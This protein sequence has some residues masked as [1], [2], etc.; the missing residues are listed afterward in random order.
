MDRLLHVLSGL[1]VGGKE[2]VVLE[3]ARRGRCEGLDHRL[4]LFDSPYRGEDVDLDPGDVPWEFIAR[5]G[6]LDLS[7]LLAL[8]RLFRERGARVVHAHNDTA[9]FYC[10]AAARL[11]GKRRPAVCG[12]FHTRPGHATRGARLLTRAASR[13]ADS[14][15]AVSAEL[16]ERLLA[17]GW[18]VRCETIW[19]GIDLAAF[20]PVGPTGG[21]R[22]RLSIPEHALVVAH[23]G[24]FDAVKRHRDLVDAARRLR[25]SGS[26]PCFV[27]VGQGP[28]CDA[29]RE[30]A[31]DLDTVRF[32]P[33]I[34]DVAAFLREIDVFVL[35][36]VHEAAP[37]VLLEAMACARS[38][39]ATEVGGIPRLLTDDSGARAAVLVPPC[40]PDL[41][42]AALAD[43]AAAPARRAAL[44]RAARARAQ[45]FSCER[46]WREYARLWQ[47]AL[48]ARR[49]L[50]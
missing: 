5:R 4:V 22:E 36:S 46:Q 7:F 45:E 26:S 18:T 37:R 10:A 25:S 40:R 39:V 6:G 23:I 21:W 12:T 35:C 9:V 20:S 49:H 11:L 42:A 32:L 15:T 43:L 28:L 19:N 41:L 29:L 3:L 16:A 44:A 48:A 50:P 27:L 33:R 1:E 38:I 2:R 14:I 8:R 24:R 30:A 13:L 34:V 47:E 17:E 31:R